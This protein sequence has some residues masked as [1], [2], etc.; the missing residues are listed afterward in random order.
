LNKTDEKKKK[1]GMKKGQ[2]HAGGN[3]KILRRVGMPLDL[4]CSAGRRDKDKRT[5]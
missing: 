1:K 5:S 4:F 2:I 3:N